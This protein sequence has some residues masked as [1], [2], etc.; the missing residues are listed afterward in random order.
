MGLSSEVFWAI[1]SLEDENL[2]T[3]IG[4]RGGFFASDPI[5][6]SAFRFG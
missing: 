1:F 3:V 2:A 4:E 5:G 6:R